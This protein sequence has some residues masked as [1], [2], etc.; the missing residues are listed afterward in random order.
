MLVEDTHGLEAGEL[1][2][3]CIQTGETQGA[4]GDMRRFVQ[5]LSQMRSETS[6]PCVLL[7]RLACERRE[8]GPANFGGAAVLHATAFLGASVAELLDPDDEPDDPDLHKEDKAQR[9]SVFAAWLLEV[10]GEPLLS[11]GAG[12]LEVAAGK[13]QLSAELQRRARGRIAS[14]LVEP[15]LRTRS[16]EEAEGMTWLA[17]AF[18][19]EAF[20]AAHPDLLADCS[21]LVGLHPDQATEAIVDCA[22]RWGKPFAVVPCCVYPKLFPERRTETGQGVTTYRGFNRYLKAKDGRICSARLPIEG[23]SLVLYAGPSTA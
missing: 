18:D 23:R 2:S 6:R 20:P 21:M 19:A 9:H 13:G 11:S 17:E 7:V 3:A 15:S 22:L 12:V 14:T 8:A 5:R 10:F 16:L 1:V 4:E